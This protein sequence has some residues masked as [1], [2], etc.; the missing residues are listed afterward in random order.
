MHWRSL[1]KRKTPCTLPPCT[2]KLTEIVATKYSQ[3]KEH[4]I[5]KTS[6]IYNRGDKCGNNKTNHSANM[7]SEQVTAQMEALEE[8]NYHLKDNQYKLNNAIAQLVSGDTTIG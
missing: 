6:S 5:I 8:R 1:G 7:V 3:F 4:C 2:Y